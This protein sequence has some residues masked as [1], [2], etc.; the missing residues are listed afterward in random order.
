[1]DIVLEIAKRAKEN[2]KFISNANTKIKNKILSDISKYLIASTEEIIKENKKDLEI[3]TQE[4]MSDSL[5]DRLKLDRKRI[6]K[7]AESIDKVIKF[8]DPVGEVVFGYNLPNGLI[9]KNIRVPLGVVGIIYEARPDVTI[10]ASVLCLKAGNCII[11]RGSS[12]A[13]NTN[14]KLVQVMGRALK[15]NDFPESIIQIIPSADREDAVRLM[16]LR[17]Y[18]DVLIPRG[19]KSLIESVV[20]NSKVPVIETGIGNCHV[21]IDNALENISMDKIAEIV[22]NAKTQRPSVCNAAEKL[23]VHK[24]VAKKI[25]PAVLKKLEEKNVKL[26]GCSISKEIYSS[27]GLASEEDWYEEYL[28]YKMAVKVVDSIEEAVMHINKYGSH[29]TETIITSNYQNSIYFTREIDSAAV[30]VNASTRFTDGEQFG[31][32]AEI[33]IST[34]KLHWRGPM[35]LRELTTNKFIVLGEGQIRE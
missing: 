5:L 15:D 14:K 25:L 21:Y 4:G 1:M 33:G 31:M 2:T 7:K 20:E 6:E 19:G 22:I 35:G 26:L 29:H 8:T 12:H 18:I 34:Q 30:F 17:R 24:D 28:D 23:L 10:D 11:L 13:L 3:S 9:L 27:I 16:Q 32:G